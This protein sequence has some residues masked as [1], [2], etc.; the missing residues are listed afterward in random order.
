[1]KMLSCS[2]LKVCWQHWAHLLLF[3]LM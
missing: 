2:V 1:M 3:P